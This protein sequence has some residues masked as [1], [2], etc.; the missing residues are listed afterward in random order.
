MQANRRIMEEK[1]LREGI[2][3][4]EVM[5]NDRLIL[6]MKIHTAYAK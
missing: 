3:L 1:T 5:D 4:P 2:T 6:E